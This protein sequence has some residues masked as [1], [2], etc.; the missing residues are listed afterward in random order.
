[1]LVLSII[2]F[3]LLVKMAWFMNNN[4]MATSSPLALESSHL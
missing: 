1:M 4:G 3:L 2:I